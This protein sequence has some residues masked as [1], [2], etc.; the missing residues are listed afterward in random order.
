MTLLGVSTDTTA[1]IFE[2]ASKVMGDNVTQAQDMQE[3]LVQAARAIGMQPGIMTQAFAR[4]APKLA[5]YG[6]NI[7]KVFKEM[8]IQSKATGIS[9]E[10]MTAVGENF[11]TFEGASRAVAQLNAMFGTQ[12]NS[13]ELMMAAAE[14]TD[15]LVDKLQN[16]FRG[17]NFEGPG[18]F[19]ALK[20]LSE[21]VGFSPKDLK[22]L[23]QGKKTVEEIQNAVQG[24]A[25][26]PME[27]NVLNSCVLLLCCGI[28]PFGTCRFGMQIS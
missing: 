9:L 26:V 3:E 28:L 20:S 6:E 8:M 10:S 15:V 18:G 7:N 4:N 23:I 16:T 5:L 14:G 19:F 24:T 13:V 1:G 22:A 17:M 27:S 11:E 2:F 12:L 21:I 25:K